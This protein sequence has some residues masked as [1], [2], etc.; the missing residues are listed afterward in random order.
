VN[1]LSARFEREYT[2]PVEPNGE[3]IIATLSEILSWC[4]AKARMQ[5]PGEGGERPLRARLCEAFLEKLFGRKAY[6]E[7][8]ERLAKVLGREVKAVTVF[9]YLLAFMNSSYA[10]ELLTTGHRPRP[11]DVFQISDEFLEELSI[12]VCRTKRELQG[13]LD[14]VEACTIART[15]KALAEAEPR[16]NTVVAQLYALR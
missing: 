14:A 6:N 3:R 11:G 13:V 10:Q 5:V 7:F 2:A 15:E 4:R 1:V 16:L 12:P 8:R 9:R